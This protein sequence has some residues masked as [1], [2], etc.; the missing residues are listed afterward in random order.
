MGFAAVHRSAFTPL[1][2]VETFQWKWLSLTKEH[3][4]PPPMSSLSPL[5]PGLLQK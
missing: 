4:L 1:Q 2:G 5:S 3:F